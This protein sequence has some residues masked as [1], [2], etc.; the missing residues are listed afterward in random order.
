MN[1]Q[2]TGSRRWP[3]AR[4]GLFF[5]LWLILTGAGIKDMPIGLLAAALGARASR[6]L[7]PRDIPPPRIGPLLTYC[8]AFMRQSLLAGLDVARRVFAPSLPLKT[9][10]AHFTP[11]LPA[12]TARTL[13]A[14]MASMAPGTLPVGE[15]TDG[16][17][18]IHC[19][20]TNSDVTS[21]L[22]ADEARLADVL[23]SKAHESGGPS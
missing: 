21:Q 4:F 14:D 10:M 6:A 8:A 7:E 18:L 22:S 9:G 12:G 2:S 1:A 15:D 16:S 5:A 11:T 13:F 3:W 20:D 23:G 17:M 19:L